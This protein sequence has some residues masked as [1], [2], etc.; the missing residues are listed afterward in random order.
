MDSAR[1][2]TPCRVAGHAR[3]SQAQPTV[4]VDEG[5]VITPRAGERPVSLE[6]VL[7]DRLEL[8]VVLRVVEL[9]GD[10]QVIVLKVC[11][12]VRGGATRSERGPGGSPRG[13]RETER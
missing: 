6:N 10:G 13:Q 4:G 2:H 3:S 5:A 8:D 12:G 1:C 9:A 7:Q 11:A